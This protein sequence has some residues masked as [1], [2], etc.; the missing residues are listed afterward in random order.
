MSKG[1]VVLALP[2]PNVP[3]LPHLNTITPSIF[4]WRITHFSLCK[5]RRSSRDC[6]SDGGVR[7]DL[8][9]SGLFAL[10]LVEFA[11]RT[12]GKAAR[13]IWASLTPRGGEATGHDPFIV[14]GHHQV[15]PGYA[16]A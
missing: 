4:L 11:P 3:L 12:A 14:K 1:Q 13:A 9:A 8:A 5:R 6:S 2:A 7:D 10:Q 15:P 16:E